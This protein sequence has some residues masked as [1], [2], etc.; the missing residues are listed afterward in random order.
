MGGVWE[1][2]MRT[3]ASSPAWLTRSCSESQFTRAVLKRRIVMTYSAVKELFLLL[4]QRR[5]RLTGSTRDGQ[6]SFTAGRGISGGSGGGASSALSR[7]YDTRRNAP[8]RGEKLGTKHAGSGNSARR[9]GKR[10]DRAMVHGDGKDEK[11]GRKERGVGGGAASGG[12]SLTT[13]KGKC[14]GAGRGRHRAADRPRN[15]GAQPWP[16]QGSGVLPARGCPE[17]LPGVAAVEVEGPSLAVHRDHDC[18]SSPSLPRPSAASQRPTPAR[19]LILHHRV[20]RAFLLPLLR[21]LSTP[22]RLPRRA[23]RQIHVARLNVS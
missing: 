8:R 18:A 14:N 20:H 9:E 17:N 3:A 15:S 10:H 11:R 23:R 7:S 13:S 16:A 12:A 19:A 1:R 4:A 2:Y 21:P 5:A 6:Q 22:P